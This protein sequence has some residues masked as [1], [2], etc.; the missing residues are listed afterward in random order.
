VNLTSSKTGLA[1]WSVDN[2]AKYLK[3]GVSPRAGVFGPMNDVVD[4]SL[5]NLSV[6]DVHAMA[7]Y[8]KS[9]PPQEPN[10]ASPSEAAVK[11][12][13]KI[14]SDH[15]AECHMASGRGGFLNSPPLA[16]SAVVQA[17][18][19][20]S[21]INIII[22]GPDEPKDI[23]F[24]AWETMKP[25]KDVLSDADVASVSNYIRGTW[26]NRAGVVTAADVARQR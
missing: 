13:A 15:C 21:L 3:T 12:G 22:Y 11:A 25:F 8:L 1:A 2:L 5:K 6:E 18:D 26:K 14:Y 24:G 7:V 10:Q 23:S 9:L 17:S 20:A 16:G 19:P 4:N